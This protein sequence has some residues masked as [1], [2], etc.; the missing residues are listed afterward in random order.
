MSC[1]CRQL[2]FNLFASVLLLIAIKQSPASSYT[3]FVSYGGVLTTLNPPNGALSNTGTIN[4]L[5]QV[6]GTY[7]V[8]SDRSSFAPLSAFEYWKGTYSD[9]VIPQQPSDAQL[10]ASINDAGVTY[11]Q[12]YTRTLP[13]NP[14]SNSYESAF[15]QDATGFHPFSLP[16]CPRSTCIQTVI[17]GMNTSGVIVGYYGNEVGGAPEFGFVDR[18]GVPVTYAIPGMFDTLVSGINESGTMWGGG[19]IGSTYES[20]IDTG[21]GANLLQLPGCVHTYI[22]GVNDSGT[23]AGTCWLTD[24]GLP[25]S[26]STAF[27]LQNGSVNFFNVMG[28]S[29][30]ELTGFNDGGDFTGTY[31]VLDPISSTPEPSSLALLGT[32]LAGLVGLRRRQR[33]FR[34]PD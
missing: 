18:S 31:Y 15:T 33:R 17:T 1:V 3:P 32:G 21:T 11:G 8:T 20:W 4:D 10:I 24:W 23:V 34:A 22:A 25:R 28:A 6:F 7:W 9:I 27:F 26:L 19:Y 2:R 12:Y 13:S 14:G 16:Q 30:T 29:G 5:G